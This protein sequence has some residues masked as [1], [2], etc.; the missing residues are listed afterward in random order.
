MPEIKAIQTE[1]KGYRFRSRLEAR[2]AVFFDEL[3][4]Q[5]QYEPDG[6]P[7]K[8]GWYLPD[9]YLPEFSIYVEIKPFDKSI[10]RYAGDGNQWEQKCREFRDTVGK[11]ILLCYGD[12]CEDLL[13]LFAWDYN[14]STGGSSEWGAL[15]AS[16]DS[17]NYLL[18]LNDAHLFDRRICVD[19]FFQ[20]EWVV[21][22]YEYIK[23]HTRSIGSLIENAAKYGKSSLTFNRLKGAKLTARG[24]RFE[25]GETPNR[26]E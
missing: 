10:V 14:D 2:W 21:T 26:K 1:Y 18:V 22:Q 13:R 19:G 3:N 8:S 16:D 23:T 7:L 15:F 20:N 5:Y 6:F 24:A 11:A 12:P 17:C 25:H 9:F 4:I